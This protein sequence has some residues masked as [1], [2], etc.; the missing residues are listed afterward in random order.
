MRKRIGRLLDEAAVFRYHRQ[1][2]KEYG[3]GSPGALGWLPDGQLIRFEVLSRIGDLAH[4]SVLDVGCGYADLYPFLQQHFAGVRYHGIEQ[5]PE[6]LAL[7]RARYGHAPGVTLT[8]GDFLR[9]PLPPSDYVLASGSLN[10]RHCNPRFIYEA[11]EKLYASCRRGLGFNL[12]SWEPA[13]GG[14]LAAHNPTAIVTFCQ[15][16]APDVQLVEGYRDGDFTVFMRR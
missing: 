3:A 8:T 4:C 15:T 1:R 13:D 9:A 10:Y 7:A 11:I 12:L 2:I 5:M 16:M 6:L 14:P